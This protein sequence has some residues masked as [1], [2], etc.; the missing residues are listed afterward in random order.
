LEEAIK[1][2]ESGFAWRML[3]DRYGVNHDTLRLAVRS[4]GTKCHIRRWKPSNPR[5]VKQLAGTTLLGT[6]EEWEYE[7]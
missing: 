5:W 4:K 3:G 6:T 1:L 7:G 2:R